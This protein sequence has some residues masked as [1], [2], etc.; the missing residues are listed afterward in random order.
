MKVKLL[1]A[2]VLIT[3]TAPAVVAAA[4]VRTGGYMS[5]F[6][7]ASIPLDA[8]V[9]TEQFSPVGTF[10]DR[11]EYDP[12]VNVGLTG[13]YNFGYLRLEGELS[14]KNAAVA[15]ITDQADGFRYRHVDGDL[16]ALAVMFNGFVDLRNDSPITPYFGG[17]IGYATLYI[18]DTY[19]TDTRGGFST[20]DLLYAE[21]VDS[22]FAYQVGGGLEIALNSILSLDLAYRY[23]GTSKARFDDDWNNVTDLKFRSHN[24]TVGLRI[25]F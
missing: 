18:S 4:P 25:K 10:N 9:T 21:D 16:S 13:G 5:G 8:N 11:V 14:Y 7:G 2:A 24:A 20:R 19:G 22:V 6:I 12:G 23:F 3:L 17:G 15:E 1:V